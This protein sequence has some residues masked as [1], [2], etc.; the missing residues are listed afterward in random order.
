MNLENSIKDVIGKKLEDGTIEKLVTEQLESGVKKA[1]DGL[2]SSY[3]DCTKIIEKQIKSVM[4][5]YL[6]NYDY[7]EYITKLDS[8]LVDVLRNTALDNKKILQNFKGL[9]S[10]E[11]NVEVI[12]VSELFKKWCEYVANDVDTDDLE[13]NTDDEPTYESVE[14]NYEFQEHDDER[15]WTKKQTGKIFFE[16]EHDENMNVCIEVYRWSDIHKENQWTFRY[17]GVKDLS[18]L[19]SLNEFQ[20]LLMKLN[21]SSAK[22][23]IDTFNEN[24]Y[25]TPEKEPELDWC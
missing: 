19:R 9:M 4:V 21:Q 2:F 6:E 17:E 22:I 13:V 8:V 23:E 16:C 20:V 25:I 11:C 10:D 3:G 14:V 7:S 15:D 5:P 18:S 1:L 12:K 24:D